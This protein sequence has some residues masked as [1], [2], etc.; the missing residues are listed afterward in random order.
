[1]GTEVIEQAAGLCNITTNHLGGIERAEIT[2]KIDTLYKITKGLNLDL[3][4]IIETVPDRYSLDDEVLP[5]LNMLDNKDFKLL[6][7]IIKDYILWKNE[8]E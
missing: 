5:L 6:N 2:P 1:M 7:K 8:K 4:K 3:N